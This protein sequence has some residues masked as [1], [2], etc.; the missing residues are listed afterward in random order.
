MID[1]LIL[2]YFALQFLTYMELYGI[3]LPPNAALYNSYLRKFIEFHSISPE[4]VIK[5]FYSDFDLDE[6]IKERKL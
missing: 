3:K 4:Q 2:L 5:W 6:F 1:Q